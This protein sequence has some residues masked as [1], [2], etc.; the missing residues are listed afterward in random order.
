MT[1]EKLNDIQLQINTLKAEVQRIDN[2]MNVM[3]QRITQLQK[4]KE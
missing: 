2:V 1:E 3:H 4:V